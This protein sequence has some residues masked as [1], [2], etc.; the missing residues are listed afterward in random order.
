[1]SVLNVGDVEIIESTLCSASCLSRIRPSLTSTCLSIPSTSEFWSDCATGGGICCAKISCHRASPGG[2]K[3][4]YLLPWPE[5][6]FT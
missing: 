2:L 1:M 3:A 5:G 6:C 4:K